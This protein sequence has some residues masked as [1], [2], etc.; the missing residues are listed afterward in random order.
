MRLTIVTDTYHP[1]ING[2]VRTLDTTVRLLQARG[3]NVTVLHP[4]LFHTCGLPRYPEIRLAID[5]WRIGAQIEQS[6]PDCLHIA[7]EGTLGFAAKLWADRRGY[8]YTTSYH[9]Q[10]PEYL[11]AHYGT[12]LRLG[13]HVLRWFHRRSAAVMA[14][15]PSMAAQ[16]AQRGFDNLVLWGRG[17]DTDAFTPEGDLDPLLASLPR[18]LWLNVGRVSAEKNLPVFYET[19]CEG[20]KVQVGDGPMLAHY[21]RAYPHVTFVGAKVGAALAACYRTADC[22]VFPSR[23]DTFGLVMLEAIAS[24]VPVAA[25]PVTGPIDVITERVNGVLHDDL[26]TA[27]AGAL[28]L[29]DRAALRASALARSWQACTDQFEQCLVPLG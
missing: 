9:T 4:A 15:T 29:T 8:A 3:H 10:F 24:G 14:N 13:Y 5:P 19:C 23:T 6:A 17:V 20:S 21:R 18:P 26:A 7:V 25:Y 22:F 11:A 28:T 12:G 1:S 16:L 2:V 27:M